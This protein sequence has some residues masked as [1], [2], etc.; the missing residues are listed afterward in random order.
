[1][2]PEKSRAGSLGERM[3]HRGRCIEVTVGT[4]IGGAITGSVAGAT[5]ID[6]LDKV[7]PQ[8]S[9]ITQLLVTAVFA[10]AGS[11]GAA[12]YAHGQVCRDDR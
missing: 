12:Y 5:I 10:A 3:T 4:A 7:L 6:K 9:L 1:M 2:F 11:I 8:E